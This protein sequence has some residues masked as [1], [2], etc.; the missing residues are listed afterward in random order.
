[1]TSTLSSTIFENPVCEPT[2]NTT[3]IDGTTSVCNL[4]M[5]N[6]NTTIALPEP[7]YYSIYYRIIGTTFLGLIFLIGILGNIMVVMVVTKSR[8]MLTP[9][10]CYLVNLSLADLMVLVASVPN[11]VLSYYLLGDEWIWGR[12]GCALFIFFQYLGINAS[13]LSITA[14]TVE[15][16]I[17]ICHPMKAQMVC[18]INRAKKII[19]GVW[20]FACL[21]CSPWL[22]LTKT[23][24]IFYKGHDNMETCTF[25]L[26][27]EYYLGYFFADL[28]LFYIL[29]LLLSCVLYSLIA[30][31]LFTSDIRRKMAKEGN[32]PRD[33][34]RN[35]NTS[36]RV[37]VVKMLAVVVAIFATLWLPYR[38]LVVYNSFA[39][40]RYME[41]WFLM[42]CKT[43]IFINSAINPIL[44][45]A[46]SV[47]FRRAFRRTLSCRK[48]Q[49]CHRGPYGSVPGSTRY[50]PST[51][52]TATTRPASCRI[53]KLQQV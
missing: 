5:D 12:V 11:E 40:H 2:N 16:Y 10:N 31:I 7:S 42:F 17:A 53:E 8:S 41:A 22:F 6:I 26:S 36:A 52:T 25:A 18:T 45:N 3:F 14:F 34:A 44:Y 38:A 49:Q 20:V 51:L 50:L 24:P 9:T 27:R 1:M 15:R 29:P 33:S 21:Y 48:Q 30:R 13:S 19:I 39:K 32:P 43:M 23:V 46:M 47:K 35:T 4:T 28:V 37:Q